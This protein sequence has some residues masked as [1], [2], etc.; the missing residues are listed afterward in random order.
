MNGQT[1]W[2]DRE[3]CDLMG[4]ESRTRLAETCGAR[5]ESPSSDLGRVKQVQAIRA[6]CMNSQVDGRG[7]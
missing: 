5:D 2:I 3:A 4:H 6:D 7:P 1:L